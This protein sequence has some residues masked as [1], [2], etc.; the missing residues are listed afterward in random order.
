[1]SSKNCVLAYSGGLDTSALVVWLIEKGYEVH[2]VL[3]DVGQDENLE[4]HCKKA[5]RMGAKTA[6]IRDAKPKMFETVIPM[7]TALAATYEGN[8]RL[9]TALARPF[10]AE[11]QVKLA[12]DLG[13]A[14]LIHGATGKGNDQVR[15]EFAYKSL[16]PD[17]PVLAPWR[18]WDFKGRKDLIAYLKGKGFDEGYEEKK[19]YSMDEN[20]WHLSVEGDV[21][22]SPEGCVDVTKVLD[23]VKDRFSAGALDVG[24]SSLEIT[25]AKGIPVAING[26]E[27]SYPELV[28]KLNQM[29]RNQSWGWDMVIE[30]RYT[31]I[32]S[33]GLYINPAAK[34]LH[35][36]VDSLAR[37]C[38]NKPTFDQWINL[39][40]QYGELLYRG[41]YFS[42]Q[43]LVLEAAAEVIIRQLNG[44][45]KVQL[46]P[47][48]YVAQIVADQP[49][50]RQE[51]ATFEES[52]YA[53]S[54]AAGFINLSWLTSVG[55]PF[56]E[57]K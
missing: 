49:I 10:I 2:A 14:T 56:S 7:A 26:V 40:L 8:Y 45:V 44:T 27:L 13:G 39:G 41:A 50:F 52:S 16:A 1:M 31:G 21:L 35:M 53:H 25:F 43:R 22:E 57:V 3:V 17:C 20:L 9:G 48:P 4:T 12:K 18:Q 34:V 29:G 30:N 11:E 38:F 46:L 37:C 6:V 23:A 5:F 36:A 19:D 15:F 32:K 55:R 54:D 28:K 24:P 33:R 51:T 42:D 47:T